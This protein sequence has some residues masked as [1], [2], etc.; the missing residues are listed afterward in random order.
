MEARLIVRGREDGQVG[1]DS[2]CRYST[3]LVSVS[4]ARRQLTVNIDLAS[5]F[6]KQIKKIWS[7]KNPYRKIGHRN[8]RQTRK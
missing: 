2:L 7:E 1:R 3:G 5:E 6:D 4:R 8:E